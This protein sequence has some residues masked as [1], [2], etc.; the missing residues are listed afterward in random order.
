[1]KSDNEKIVR[2]R[3]K[4]LE[5]FLKK[6]YDSTGMSLI[7]KEL[8]ISK[9]GLFHYYH[10]K[11]ELL[12]DIIIGRMDS[13]FIPILEGA[14]K[15]GDAKE[16][17]IY[18]IDKFTQIMTNNNEAKVIMHDSQRLNH[19]HYMEIKYIWRQTFDFLCDALS[20]L[21]RSGES[22]DLNSKFVAFG[23]LGVCSWVFYWFDYSRKES[24]QELADTFV[25]FCT[26]GFLKVDD[27]D[28][29][30]RN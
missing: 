2:I 4:A 19:A 16:R 26:S 17:I 5:L 30:V 29:S 24:S 8:G 14:R 18:F 3:E 27:S 9:G 10:T 1:M 6:G 25:E 7:A 28:I 21:Q 23:I 11:E 13:I 15:I 22:K 12:Y 20:E